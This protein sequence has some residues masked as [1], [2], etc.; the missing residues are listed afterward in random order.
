MFAHVRF[1]MVNFTTSKLLMLSQ[2]IVFEFVMLI[3]LF[4]LGV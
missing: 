3:F 1:D 4:N 2:I